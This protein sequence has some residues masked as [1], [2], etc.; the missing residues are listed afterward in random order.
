MSEQR[1]FKVG[2]KV[3]WY[4]IE[5]RPLWN[6][7]GTKTLMHGPSK[8]VEG[9]VTS[10]TDAVVCVS[11]GW[12]WPQPDRSDARYGEP[13]YLE[14]VEAAPEPRYRVVG[15][16]AACSVYIEDGS[17]WLS[18]FPESCRAELEAICERLNAVQEP[19]DG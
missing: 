6:C 15:A 13:G 4:E 12:L 14:L 9:V 18:L 1:K 11:G 3:R 5:C 17:V 16:P 2:D 8:W 7:N 10:T 19:D